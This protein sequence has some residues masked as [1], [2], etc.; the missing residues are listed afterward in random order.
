MGD[1]AKKVSRPLDLCFDSECKFDWSDLAATIDVDGALQEKDLMGFFLCVPVRKEPFYWYYPLLAKLKIPADELVQV[2]QLDISKGISLETLVTSLTFKSPISVFKMI[3]YA[4]RH[5]KFSS[6]HH[7]LCFMD[8]ITKGVIYPDKKSKGHLLMPDKAVFAP[9]L[10]AMMTKSAAL[11]AHII[12]VLMQEDETGVRKE[13]KAL[14]AAHEK[15]Y[16]L[17]QCLSVLGDFPTDQ[18]ETRDCW[19]SPDVAF[20][21]LYEQNQFCAADDLQKLRFNRSRGLAF[22]PQG[23]QL[24]NSKVKNSSLPNASVWM[25]TM[26]PDSVIVSASEFIRVYRNLRFEYKLTNVQRSHFRCN[27]RQLSILSSRNVSGLVKEAISEAVET[28]C[29]QSNEMLREEFKERF[30]EAS[31]SSHELMKQEMATVA[32]RQQLQEKRMDTLDSENKIQTSMLVATNPAIAEQFPTMLENVLHPE[33]IEEAISANKTEKAEIATIAK[34]IDEGYRFDLKSLPA[35]STKKI[36]I[37]TIKSFRTIPSLQYLKPVQPHVL[38][39]VTTS[40]SG[41]NLLGNGVKPQQLKVR[42]SI[43]GSFSLSELDSN[44]SVVSSV[45]T[46]SLSIGSIARNDLGALNW[47]IQNPWENT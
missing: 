33:D 7:C 24:A 3:I 16:D 4:E 37:P 28:K 18:L 41:T 11:P 14:R 9:L 29:L 15:D 30:D 6:V 32:C 12:R 23:F 40:V 45:S 27:E 26:G 10:G 34:K 39:A 22:T 44:L 19:L 20:N 46:Q 47:N 13:L 42:S 5:L 8:M 31:K 2:N 36:D 38:P 1:R 21:R 25:A 35:C 43:N 17:D